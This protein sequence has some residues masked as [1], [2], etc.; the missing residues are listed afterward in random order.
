[1]KHDHTYTEPYWY[2]ELQWFNKNGCEYIVGRKTIDNLS[3]K[4]LRNL[5][6]IGDEDDP[7]LIYAYII[8][9]NEVHK[10]Q[11]YIQHKIDIKKYDY[12]TAVYA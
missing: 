11:K 6:L 8:S 1:L 7:V 5:L 3:P 2:R 10:L 4:F 12:Y 9:D